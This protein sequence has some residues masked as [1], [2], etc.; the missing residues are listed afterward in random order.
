M[1]LKNCT[2]Y[3]IYNIIYY[4]ELPLGNN[5]PAAD[6]MLPKNCGR[7]NLAF[8]ICLRPSLGLRFFYFGNFLWLRLQ[9]EQETNPMRMLELGCCTELRISQVRFNQSVLI[10]GALDPEWRRRLLLHGVDS[11]GETLLTVRSS[12]SRGWATWCYKIRLPRTIL[13]KEAIVASWAW[14]VRS[15]F[16]ALVRSPSSSQWAAPVIAHNSSSEISLLH[17]EDLNQ[18]W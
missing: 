8:A 12:F 7:E 2:E 14:Y 11:W 3:T 15:C 13:L 10:W 6:P 4:T 5:P 1:L 17:E 9:R 18:L 16:Y